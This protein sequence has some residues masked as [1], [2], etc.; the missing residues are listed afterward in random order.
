MASRIP[1]YSSDDFATAEVVRAVLGM[2]RASR[3]YRHLVREQQIAKSVATYAYPLL[4][5]ASMLLTWG[6]GY[7]E[8]DPDL[9]E[10]A[11]TREMEALIDTREEEINRAI[12]LIETDLVR[13]LERVAE[14]ADLLSMFDLYFGDPGRLNGELDRLRSVTLN[15]VRTFVTDQLGP[16]NRAVLTYVPEGRR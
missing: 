11:M 3:L 1:P 6:T 7:P 12:S 8:T 13:T 4:T 10:K 5:G 16:D 14:R 2:G 9:L 15:D